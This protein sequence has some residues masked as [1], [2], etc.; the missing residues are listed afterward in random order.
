M[1]L[2][3][4]ESPKSKKSLTIRKKI[5]LSII[6]LIVG[7]LIF[8]IAYIGMKQ[9]IGLAVFNQPVLSWM[10]SHRTVN[11]TTI[12]KIITTIANPLVFAFIVGVVVIFWAIQ[13][14]EI[15]RP[16]LLACSVAV[17]AVTSAVLKIFIMDARPP[18]VDMV[19]VFE[20][21]FSFPSGHTIGVAVFL[22]VIGYLI[23][24]RS[25]GTFKFWVWIC[26]A[27]IGTGI[28]ALTR[29]Y[30]GY[31]WLT[32]VVASAGL[33]LIILAIVIVVDVIFVKRFKT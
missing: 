16:T 27:A 33:A 31:H 29:L 6:C 15:W 17:A 9:K 10:I 24:S 4:K 13:K 22:L 23:Y 3:V 12:A 5:A 14:R 7:I 28:I 11:I 26:I 8:V 32:D 19:P 21:D 25:F 20:N 30:L 1:T 18:H 2:S